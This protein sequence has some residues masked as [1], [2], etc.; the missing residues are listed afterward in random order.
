MTRRLTNIRIP[1]N[2]TRKVGTIS[3]GKQNTDNSHREDVEYECLFVTGTSAML[4]FQAVWSRRHFLWHLHR[5]SAGT[6]GMA[7]SRTSTV[8]N[9]C[10]SFGIRKEPSVFKT[11]PKAFRYG[12]RSGNGFAAW[13][14][15]RRL[16]RASSRSTA[17]GCGES[18]GTASSLA[19]T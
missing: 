12:S 10:S 11:R 15:G 3:S 8:G 13:S 6:F 9:C 14:W 2:P 1:A 16:D 18:R 4:P 5:M 7:R 19:K 17:A